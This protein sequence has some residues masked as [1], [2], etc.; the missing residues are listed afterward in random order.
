[1]EIRNLQGVEKLELPI[2][3][4][5][6][7]KK[8]VDGIE[9]YASDALKTHPFH[10]TSKVLLKQIE[11]YP[12]L[13]SGFSNFSLL[14]KHN[15]TIDLLLAALFPE[16]LSTNEIKTAT[17]PFSFT[18]FKFTKR[19]K[20]I[21][22]NAG[23]D[24]ELKVRNFE[25]DTMYIFVCTFILNYVY[26]FTVD[27]KRPFYFDIPD[28]KLGIT[29]HYKVAINADFME[30]IPTDK[31]PVITE[32]DYKLLLENFDNI[33]LWKE[34]FP[35]ESYILKGFAIMNLFDVSV[36][37]T[38]TAIR[39][40]LLRKDDGSILKNLQKNLSAFFAIRDLKVGYS[41]FDVGNVN[42]R[43]L[44]VKRSESILLEDSTS[45]TCKDFFV[46]I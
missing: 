9:R 35:P 30:V 20:T 41:V 18:S 24:Y 5:I 33:A 2:S 19:F 37:E 15:E 7:F 38:L 31:A 22:E 23:E 8:I 28:Q 46:T 1:M 10:Q 11:Q 3:F 34:K 12:E 16:I 26:K 36:D 44:R 13:I 14:E 17:I 32:E 42:E 39:T 21:L 40:N 43:S 45:V 25:D 4:S 6:S 29:K 27:L